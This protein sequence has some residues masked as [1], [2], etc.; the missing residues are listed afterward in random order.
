MEVGITRGMEGERRGRWLQRKRVC[1]MLC[2]RAISRFSW[3]QTSTGLAFDN[4]T[5]YTCNKTTPTNVVVVVLLAL[6]PPGLS[7]ARNASI[8][9]SRCIYLKCNYP[10]IIRLLIL[11][12]SQRN[13]TTC[14]STLSFCFC[15]FRVRFTF[16]FRRFW[17]RLGA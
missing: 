16:S 13:P 4:K 8:T 17:F 10:C 2:S 5:M 7:Q 9:S 14:N 12:L 6:P 1:M 15:L 11:L 3:S